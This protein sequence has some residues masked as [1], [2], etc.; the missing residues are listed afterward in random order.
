MRCFIAIDIDK[1]F[2]NKIVEIQERIK[3]TDANVKFVEPE[4]LH[5]TVKF[6]GDVNEN[7][8][9]AI[10]HSLNFL[11]NEHS[12]KI[13]IGGVGYFG[14]PNYIRTLWV[15]IKDGEDEMK[16]IMKKVNFHV[17]FGER[18]A[19][20]HLTIGRVKSGKN[21]ENLTGLIGQCKDVK[22]GE[23]DVKEIKLKS[24]VLTAKGPVYDD[25]STFALR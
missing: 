12:F 14:G 25:I 3:S 9:E 17:R 2:R 1:G 19:S 13:V 21:L 23:M 6:I 15:G 16:D 10:K 11:K 4:N 22:I 24:S 8:L 5:F 7:E 20:P 18:E